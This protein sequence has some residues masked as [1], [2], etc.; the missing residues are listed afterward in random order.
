MF[1]LVLSKIVVED[2]C[3]TYERRGLSKYVWLFQHFASNIMLRYS[4]R[5][6]CSFR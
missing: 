5:T 1:Q 2:L 3:S 6:S 4:T